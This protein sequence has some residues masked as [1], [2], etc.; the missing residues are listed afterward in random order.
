MENVKN[1]TVRTIVTLYYLLG[2]LNFST[3]KHIHYNLKTKK[4]N[5]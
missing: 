3:L 5:K 1:N 4:L 2:N